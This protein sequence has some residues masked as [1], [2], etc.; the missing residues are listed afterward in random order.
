M[1]KNDFSY[2]WRIH[3]TDGTVI[4]QYDN[5]GVE[6]SSSSVDSKQVKALEFIPQNDEKQPIAIHIGDDEK[7]INF[8]RQYKTKDGKSVN[9]LVIA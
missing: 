3:Y 8:W 7:Y 9:R 6:V 2:S 4:D 1:E 5:D